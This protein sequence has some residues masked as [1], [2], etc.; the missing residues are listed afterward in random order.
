MF[1]N[2]NQNVR[3]GGQS[4]T[5]AKAYSEAVRHALEVWELITSQNHQGDLAPSLPLTKRKDVKNKAHKAL[6]MVF[7]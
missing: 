6:L 3:T 1:K 5:T 2:P 7:V 4:R